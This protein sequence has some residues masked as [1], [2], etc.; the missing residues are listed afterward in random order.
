MMTLRLA[1]LFA[2]VSSLAAQVSLAHI[3]TIDVSI[4][5][6]AANSEF[7]GS[8]PSAVAWDGTD[9]WL[10]GFNNSGSMGDVAIIKIAN[11]FAAP[12]YGVP[13]G[14]QSNVGPGSGSGS[15]SFALPVTA[16]G[17]DL[18]CQG[19]ILESGD[20]SMTRTTNGVQLT[21]Q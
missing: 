5:S 13:F 12:S 16:S 15:L 3:G 18:T 8:H 6:N 17:L 19:A 4:T 21:V 20:V 9:L 10:A 1:A 14:Q 11:A 7:I 2:A